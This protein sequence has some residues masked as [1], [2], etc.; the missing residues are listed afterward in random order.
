[1]PE[2]GRLRIDARNRVLTERD[3]RADQELTPGE[4]VLLSVIDDGSGMSA[5]DVAKAFEP[6]YTT[7]AV[8]RGSGL[9]L[10]MVY[11]F[12]NQSKGLVRISSA[13]GAGTT[14]ELFLPRAP[15]EAPDMPERVEP[16]VETPAQG[17]SILVV[18]DEER[19]RRFVVK[20]L[21]MLG[22]RVHQA[23]TASVALELLREP[24]PVDLLLSDVVLRGR[25]S[26]VELVRQARTLFPELAVLLMSG[27]AANA[28]REG[29][30][31]DPGV[32]LLGKPFSRDDLA[33][34]VRRVLS[35][36]TAS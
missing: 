21:R 17:E 6:F 27:Y 23:G 24:I 8:G 14:V 2:G 26:G 19:V 13:L 29:K 30:G 20:A 11:G 7:K 28:I 25:M 12:V 36:R 4:F 31:L 35:D 5:E 22:Y 3:L 15:A 18:E 10:S 34:A 33:R 1:M 16:E 9:G 32:E